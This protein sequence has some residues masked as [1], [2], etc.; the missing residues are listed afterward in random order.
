[1]SLSHQQINTPLPYQWWCSPVGWHGNSMVLLPLQHWTIFRITWHH[2]NS[3]APTVWSSII[4]LLWA[5]RSLQTLAVPNMNCFCSI[6]PNDI[7]PPQSISKSI[8]NR[9][10]KWI[11]KQLVQKEAKR[12]DWTNMLCTRV[13][14]R[15]RNPMTL[16]GVLKSKRVV[17]WEG[18]NLLVHWIR[19]RRFQRESRSWRYARWRDSI[20]SILERSNWERFGSSGQTLTRDARKK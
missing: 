1:M 8:S 19:T 10:W 5:T 17:V 16:L 7:D 2:I 13:F 15:E 12:F 18:A 3:T 6:V 9:N 14:T 20:S 4:V 11:T